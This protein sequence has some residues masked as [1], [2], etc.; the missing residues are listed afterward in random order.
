[1]QLVSIFLLS[2]ASSKAKMSATGLY[3]TV[4]DV[5]HDLERAQAHG[6]EPNGFSFEGADPAGVDY[7]LDRAISAWYDGKEWLNLLCKR[8]MEQ[9]WSWN[10][11][12]LEY[13]ELYHA[14]HKY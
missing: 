1:M 9:D 14:A 5:D 12:A 8:V 2:L 4:F 6:L 13:I 7:A 11:P 10:R 3:D